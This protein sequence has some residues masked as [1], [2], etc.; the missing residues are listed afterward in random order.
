MNEAMAVSC[1]DGVPRCRLHGLRMLD[2]TIFSAIPFSSADSCNVARNIGIDSRW[3]G[4]MYLRGL[5]K[6]DRAMVMAARIEAHASASTWTPRTE[7]MNF[8]LVG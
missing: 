3:D 1:R 2:P 4:H 8:S 7:Q 6:S 5:S